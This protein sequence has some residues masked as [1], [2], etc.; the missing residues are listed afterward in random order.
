ME[1]RKEM[2][3]LTTHSTYVT[4]PATPSGLFNDALDTF[5]LR[6]YGIRHMVKEGSCACHCS[7]NTTQIVYLTTHSTHLRLYGIRHMVKEGSCACHCSCNTTQIVYLTTHSTHL[8]LYGIRHM[9]K[10][11]SCACHCSCNTTQWNR[12][13]NNA[14]NTFYL[15]LYGYVASDIW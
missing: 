9:V 2:V 3:Y 1:G 7:C 12:L 4:V 13:V 5:H 8:R 14:L 10:E 15:R 6:L 11:G